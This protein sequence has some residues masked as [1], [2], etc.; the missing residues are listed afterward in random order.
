MRTETVNTDKLVFEWEDDDEVASSMNRTKRAIILVGKHHASTGRV[1]AGHRR[2]MK[3]HIN[4]QAV[5]NAGVGNIMQ[6]ITA[7]PALCHSSFEE[8]R[9]ECYLQSMI[10]KGAPP[11]PVD[12]L[13]TP[14]AVIQPTFREFRSDHEHDA[15][16]FDSPMSSDENKDS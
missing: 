4:S 10:A 5:R 3:A 15:H 12:P 9:L 7:T 16:I 11:A 13:E 1:V 14:W 2:A 6:S 8:L